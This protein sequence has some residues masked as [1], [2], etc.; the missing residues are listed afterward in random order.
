MKTQYYTAS[1]LDG[2]LADE[3]D[4]L[5]RLL[6]QPTGEGGILPMDDFL[7][8]VGAIVTGRTT[9]QWVLDHEESVEGAWAG[10]GEPLLDGRFDLELLEHGTDGALLEARYRMVGERR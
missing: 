1:S 5:D 4:S 6:S 8:E 3:H 9:F 10:A 7:A 2:F